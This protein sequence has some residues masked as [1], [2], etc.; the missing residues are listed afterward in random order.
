MTHHADIDYQTM[1]PLYWVHFLHSSANT[2]KWDSHTWVFWTWVWHIEV[3]FLT[4]SVG[5]YH[6]W[7]QDTACYF[8]LWS[9][10]QTVNVTSWHPPS[11][12]WEQVSAFTGHHSLSTSH[13]LEVGIA[14]SHP[15]YFINVAPIKFPSFC[16]LLPCD[17]D[18]LMPSWLVFIIGDALSG[19]LWICPKV[20]EEEIRR[21]NCR[22]DWHHEARKLWEL[23]TGRPHP[24]GLTWQDWLTSQIKGHPFIRHSGTDSS[25]WRNKSH[26]WGSQNSAETTTRSWPPSRLN[27]VNTPWWSRT[28]W[29]WGTDEEH[30]RINEKA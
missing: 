3:R 9:S 21:C 20:K 26:C 25:R 7:V 1:V 4:P 2:S 16:D 14:T 10:H 30:L 28:F 8:A 29:R 18:H 11:H 6:T 15:Q 12:L 19:C 22:T 17:T 27:A 13:M 24:C 5:C 23:Q